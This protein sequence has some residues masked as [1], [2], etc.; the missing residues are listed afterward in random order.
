MAPRRHLRRIHVL[1]ARRLIS[2]ISTPIATL[3]IRRLRIQHLRRLRSPRRARELHARR[4]HCRAWDLRT[5]RGVDT[6]WS[7]GGRTA[8]SCWERVGVGAVRLVCHAF[9]DPGL[10]FFGALAD[11]GGGD[12]EFAEVGVVGRDAYGE[13]VFA[14]DG[15]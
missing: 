13:E 14:E 1:I 8:A 5:S 2:P 11:D 12:E 10:C 9:G 15:G 6:A 7:L 3:L 4:R